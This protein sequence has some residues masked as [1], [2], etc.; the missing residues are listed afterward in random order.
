M[1]YSMV[2]TRRLSAFKCIQVRSSLSV[3]VKRQVGMLRAFN[4]EEM[5]ALERSEKLNA[6]I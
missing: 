4:L 5:N 2:P 3:Q 1:Q 6:K